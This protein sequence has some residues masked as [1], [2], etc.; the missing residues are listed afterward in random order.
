MPVVPFHISSAS[1]AVRRNGG[2]VSDLTLPLQGA[3][4]IPGT[5]RPTAYLK[6]LLFPN[7][8]ANC[9]AATNTSSVSLGLGDGH[10]EFTNGGAGVA[11]WLG[12]AFDDADGAAQQVCMDVPLRSGGFVHR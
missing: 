5:A 2:R 3:L 11:Y 9:T 12:I 1:N 10:I 7:E 6:S 8:L 4:Q